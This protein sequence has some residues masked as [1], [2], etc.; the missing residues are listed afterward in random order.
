MSLNIIKNY[1][2][3]NGK[4]LTRRSN[5]V[6]SKVVAAR[7]EAAAILAAAKNRAEEIERHALNDAEELRH[8]AYEDGKERALAEFTDV[9]AA[10]HEKRERILT[11]VEQ[12][13]LRLAIKLAEKIIGHEIENNQA[14][15]AD[16][17][18]AAL[19]HVR[20]QERLIVR[21]NPTDYPQLEEFKSQ[22][23]QAGRA[24]FLDLEPDPKI[25]TGGCI[26]ESEVGTVD[27][28]LETQLRILERALLNQ[29][30]ADSD[31]G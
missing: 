16:M 9:I 1:P 17:V 4:D 12:D 18:T 28:R 8:A 10:A 20:Q 19:R 5:L 14:V 13:V 29:A 11:E 3:A 30:K 27:A 15:V 25:P 6:K 21:V 24:Q 31:A 7:D 23:S 2:V 26:I 22:L